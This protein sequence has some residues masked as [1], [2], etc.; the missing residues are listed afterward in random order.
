M[1]NRNEG[2]SAAAILA[3]D[4]AA[5]V[6]GLGNI[7]D[8]AKAA[9]KAT[10]LLKF[11]NLNNITTSSATASAGSGS[12]IADIN[13]INGA[14]DETEGILGEVDARMEALV[15]NVQ[16]F[17]GRIKEIINDFKVGDFFKAGKDTSDLA[18]DILDFFSDAIDNVDW[19]GI[20][21]KIGEFLAGIDWLDVI[22][23]G[24]K[25]KFEIWKAIAEIWFGSFKAAPVETAI[26]TALGLLK[27]TG[28]DKVLGGKIATKIQEGITEGVPK[29]FTKVSNAWTEL[30]GLGGILTTDVGKVL[31]SGDA[32]K[33]GT[34]LGVG[35]AASAAAAIG[36]WNLGQYL[37]EQCTGE[38]IDMSF[39]EQVS[40]LADA[41]NTGELSQAVKDWWNDDVVAFY[42]EKLGGILEGFDKW[43]NNVAK[44]F[45]EAFD[46]TPLV[47]GWNSIVNW[48][49]GNVVPWFTK[50]K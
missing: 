35:I 7:E 41:F 47:E 17:A 21:T 38:D 31:S 27:F 23:K 16:V 11:D 33:I 22:K 14:A 24:F 49:D 34:M 26:I 40:Y 45:K 25:L 6:T 39:T 42:E 13:A 9:A 44:N 8:A 19:D 36:G 3:D 2:Q 30:G 5:A 1:G 10:G 37:Y 46:F 43:K 29:L 50:E 48:F 12:A 15:G 18:A 4:S 32:A 28:L 20:G